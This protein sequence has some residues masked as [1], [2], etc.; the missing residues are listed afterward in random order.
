MEV[1]QTERDP[2]I[3]HPVNTSEDSDITN[4]N[5]NENNDFSFSKISRQKK[6]LLASMAMV[7]FFSVTCFSLLAPFFPAEVYFFLIYKL[8]IYT[9]IYIIY[10]TTFC[11]C[12]C[13]IRNILE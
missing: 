2:L 10:I 5:E 1:E 9:G 8:Y 6:I 7:N 12:K 11:M 3:K 4:K 13:I